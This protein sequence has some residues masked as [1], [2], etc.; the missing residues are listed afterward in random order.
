MERMEISK[1]LERSETGGVWGYGPSA[2]SP[3]KGTSPMPKS[4]TILNN[5]F[6]LTGFG[7]PPSTCWHVLKTIIAINASITSPILEE[8]VSKSYDQTQSFNL[9]WNDTD[10]R[11]PAKPDST[12]IEQT[13]VK[14]ICSPFDLGQNFG[15]MF[16][17]TSG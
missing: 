3:R 17:D 13:H 16:R 14:T 1:I 6:T 12:A 4:S 5:I 8:T 15:I 2:I 11:G 10:D 7:R 9:P